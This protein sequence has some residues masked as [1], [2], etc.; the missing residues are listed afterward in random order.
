M[1]NIIPLALVFLFVFF[2]TEKISA[3][4]SPDTIPDDNPLQQQIEDLSENLGSESVDLTT[5]T[6]NLKYYKS[7]PLNLNTATREQ[8]EDLM[9]LNPIQIDNLLAHRDQFGPLMTIYELQT[10][11]G[12]DLATI[13]QILPYVRVSD[14]ANEG[15]FN[16]H[17]MVKNGQ[18]VLAVRDQRI[19]EQ[20]KGFSPITNEALAANPNAR[21]LGN[22][23]HLYARYD[24]TYGNYVSAGITADKDAGE[25]FFNGTEKRGFDFYSAH[26]CVRNIG[27]VK[28]AAVGDYQVSFGQGLVAWTGYAFGMTSMSLNDKKN[29]QGIRPY[30]SVDENKF[31][32]GAATTLKF[33]KIETTVF[34]SDKKRDANVAVSDTTG[35]KN[36]E[37]LEVSSLE[38]TGLHN[39]VAS[40]ADRHSLTEIIAGGNVT[41]RVN[42]FE[43]GVTEMY[44]HYSAP[45]NRNLSLYNQFEFS[46]Q[47]NN[48]VGAD[49]DW[50]LH[51]FHFFGEEAMSAN[52]G[53]A[54][55]NGVLVSLDP[56]LAITIH[57][58]WLGR[59]YQNIY[60][61]VFSQGTTVA[62]ERG[63]YFGM[64]AQLLPHVT[65]SA[66]YDHAFY[67]WLRYEIN[68]PSQ[69]TD[70]LAQLNYIPDKK[71][72][73]YLRYRHR[74]KFLNAGDATVPLDYITPLT[75]DNYRFNIEYPF[76]KSFTL[77]NR[78]EY[79]QYHKSN[80]GVDNGFVIWQEIKYH[81][82]RSKFSFSAR[83]ALFQ[84]DSYSSAIYAFEDELPNTFLVPAYYYK[85]SRAYL[86]VS[87]NVSRKLELYFRISQ[88]YYNNENV[89]SAGTL[90]E[91]D[92]NTKTE[93]EAMVRMK[94]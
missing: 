2:S 59:D 18:S 78:V 56:R 70:L 46:A 6:E 77:G 61:N 24:F 3:Q 27:I 76:G 21:Y 45:L 75:E 13:Y 48:V 39:T 37:V 73:M 55:I 57:T 91:I 93:L 17:E 22:K 33:G 41:Y 29:P 32:R 14:N 79:S 69:G 86:L 50:S 11:D 1:K 85:G 51:N 31:L 49:Y 81:K 44:S 42:R 88:T 67:P 65:F 43:I 66:Y 58:R 89:I 74:D 4:V 20:Q 71:T 63:I 36:I 84:T 80:S 53:V 9:L 90:D 54:F 40:M 19:V 15:H 38:T 16:F 8:L 12:F 5:L 60:A 94:F 35:G 7:H 52:G 82:M 64:L 68:A 47:K 87:Y 28:T 26:L 92:K 72:I 10:I 83:Y 62:N 25:Q 23:D 34:A 30:T